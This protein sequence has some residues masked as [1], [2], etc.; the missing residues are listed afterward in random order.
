M[1]IEPAIFH[2]QHRF[3]D[4]RR[5]LRQWNPFTHL[6]RLTAQPADKFRFQKDGKE[7]RPVKLETGPPPLVPDPMAASPSSAYIGFRLRMEIDRQGLFGQA[8]VAGRLH[9]DI[10]RR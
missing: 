9:R 5:N 7:R 3:N 6:A 2:G 8:I 10:H 1:R 4:P